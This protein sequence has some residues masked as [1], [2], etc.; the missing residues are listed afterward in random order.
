MEWSGNNYK[1]SQ[2]VKKIFADL[3]VFCGPKFEGLHGW[4]NI[5]LFLVII[6]LVPSGDFLFPN[7]LHQFAI[8]MGCHRT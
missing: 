5:A 7:S 1:L 3:F 8:Y 4:A 2:I 6:R